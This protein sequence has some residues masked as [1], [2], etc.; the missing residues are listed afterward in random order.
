M[1]LETLDIIIE[2]LPL[3]AAFLFAINFFFNKGV[4]VRSNEYLGLFF[5]AFVLVQIFLV[6]SGLTDDKYGKLLLPLIVGGS[7]IIPPSMYFYVNS[8]IIAGKKINANRHFIIG[9]FFFIINFIIYSLL[10][11]IDKESPI[12]SPVINY[13]EFITLYPI[14]FIFPLLS[15]YYIYLSFKVLKRHQIDIGD[16][17]S[18]AEGINLQW[19][20]LFLVG[21]GCWFIATV[22]D[23]FINYGSIENENFI[24]KHTYDF[25][26]T[27]YIVFVGLKALQQQAF[28]KVLFNSQIDFKEEVLEEV[29]AAEENEL[30]DNK[31]LEIWKRSEEVMSINSPFTDVN[32]T[33]YDLAR[34]VETN[35]KYLSKA[36]KQSSN[37]NFVSYINSYRVQESM[38]LLK[39][40]EYNNYTIEA[41]AE[42]SGFKSKSAFNTAFKKMTNQTPSE[43]KRV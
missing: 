24:G 26:T 30:E 9:S 19:V 40:E 25:I 42:M 3:C 2:S 14:I 17:Y 5:L 1:N 12:I 31:Y 43:F 41:L 15:I 8:L 7:L 21:F 36:I 23:G 29:K 38:L 20:K 27:I 6:F 33:I 35:Y 39:N 32:L 34:L 28:D 4:K 18:Y 13:I 22:L 37:Q 16:I 10:I 11:F